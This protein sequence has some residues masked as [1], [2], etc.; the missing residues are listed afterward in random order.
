MANAGGDGI[1]KAVHHSTDKDNLKIDW[2]E[3][4]TCIRLLAMK[5]GVSLDIDTELQVNSKVNRAP[6]EATGTLLSEHWSDI[7][8]FLAGTTVG[9]FKTSSHVIA[10][11]WH[12]KL[13]DFKE[14]IVVAQYLEVFPKL[15]ARYQLSE[16][17]R[18]ANRDSVDQ[19]EGE[20]VD[21]LNF[22]EFKSVMI[23][24]GIA[25]ELELPILCNSRNLASKVT[26]PLKKEVSI[27]SN[28]N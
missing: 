1:F 24:I 18:A 14:F 13:M 11:D 28:L 16:I 22:D 26:F 8:F 17:F 20:D 21:E 9:P 3:H 27:A 5:A 25:L 4:Q 10:A 19:G 2:Y 12:L 6:R 7:H 15:I 23:G